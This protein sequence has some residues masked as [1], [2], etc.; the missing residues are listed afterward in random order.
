[1]LAIGLIVANNS[2]QGAAFFNSSNAFT[3]SVLKTRSD[4][5]DFF[6]LAEANSALLT[7]NAELLSEL[8]L[9]KEIPDSTFIALDSALEE[10]FE[11]KGARIISNSLRFGQ[12]HLTLNK[13]SKDGIKPGM[14]IFNEQGVIGRVKSVS[15]N[16]SVGISLLNTGLTLS[17]KLKTNN[18][19]GTTNWDGKDSEH[20]R[21]LYVP[22]H[23][24][25]NV[26][27]TI[28]TTGFSNVFPEGIPIG[29]IS[30][31]EKGEDPNFLDIMID[32]ST[33]FS[34]AHYVYL[35]ENNQI[36]ELDSLHQQAEIKDEL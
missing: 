24:V 26:G 20:A 23:V 9:L 15:A 31:V 35:V 17:S 8:K 30:S 13:G 36:E 5:A 2:P 29:I 27:D 18:S 25:A 21:L 7:K 19:F 22:S 12:N 34:S 16:Y 3:G 33:D 28:V 6:S 10:K 1:V 4:V 14:G 11:F 32:L